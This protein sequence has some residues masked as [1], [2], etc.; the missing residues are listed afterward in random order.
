VSAQP[1]SRADRNRLRRLEVPRNDTPEERRQRRESLRRSFAGIDRGV[2]PNPI[3]WRNLPP[4]DY[5]ADIEAVVERYRG[6]P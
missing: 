4:R 1:F 3:D 6:A 2:D 5:L